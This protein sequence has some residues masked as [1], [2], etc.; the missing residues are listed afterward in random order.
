VQN[1]VE[2]PWAY[3]ITVVAQ[4]LNHLKAEDAPFGSVMQNMHTHECQRYATAYYIVHRYRISI[5]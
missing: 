3:G 5:L 1:R 2:R 4:L